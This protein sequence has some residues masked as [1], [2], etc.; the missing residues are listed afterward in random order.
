MKRPRYMLEQLEGR[1]LLAA[2]AYDWKN[3]NIGGG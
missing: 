2:Q 3:V 1:L